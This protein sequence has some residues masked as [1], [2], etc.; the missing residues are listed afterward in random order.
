[1][2]VAL[3]AGGAWAALGGRDDAPPPPPPEAIG[4]GVALGIPARSAEVSP[5]PVD[6]GAPIEV[7]VPTPTDGLPVLATGS[8]SGA[9]ASPPDR[10]SPAGSG[11][12][13]SA[14]L[15]DAIAGSQDERTPR[16][17]DLGDGV[18]E[19]NFAYLASYTFQFRGPLKH[20]IPDEVALLSGQ[21]VQLEGYMLP[22]KVDNG[23]LAKWLFVRHFNNCCFGRAPEITEV[24]DV[25]TEPDERTTFVPD[26]VVVR[27]VLEV[28]VVF[29]E[30]GD[31]SSVYRIQPRSISVIR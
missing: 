3:A 27:G 29:D 17:R 28:G 18:I 25:V 23:K 2:A 30:R 13:S 26:T 22:L 5:P 10:P 8:G 4:R 16:R 6:P 24:I 7:V 11:S 21:V 15:I 19:I 20:R 31:P 1:M 14:Y 12:G 9:V